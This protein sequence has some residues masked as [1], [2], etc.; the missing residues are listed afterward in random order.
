MAASSVIDRKRHRVRLVPQERSVEADSEQS[1][2]EAA[3]SAGIN[4]P[5]SCKSGHCGSCR[6]RLLSGEV[7]A[8]ALPPLGLS[9]AEAASGHVLL[10]QVRALSDVVIE[11]RSVATVSATVI[12]TLPCRIASL[13]PLAPDVLRVMLRLPAIEPLDFAPGQYLDVLLPQGGRRSFSIACPPHHSELIEL[14]VR[15]VPGG[16]FTESLFGSVREGALLRIEGPLGHFLYHER[17]QPALMVAGGTGF[18]PIK[19]MLAHLLASGSTR[20]VHL[21]WGARTARDLYEESLVL[22]W[23]RQHPQLRF[24]GVLSHSD[25]VA[26]EH[27]RLGW[28]HECVLAEHAT[29]E[30]FDVYVAGPPE[31]IQAVRREFPPRGVAPERLQFDSFD[32]APR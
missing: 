23:A 10:C 7:S 31:L 21:Y 19:A 17:P 16:C 27:H 6:A 12:K 3:R 18:A 11:A 26:R 30:P 20:P 1:I 14:H 4:L 29:L 13:T 9:A 28:V 8:P 25:S 32:Y 24:R 22:E 2:L 5:H 15:R